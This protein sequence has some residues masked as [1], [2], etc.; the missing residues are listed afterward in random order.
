MT[1]NTTRER[2]YAGGGWQNWI[3]LL[4]GIWLFISP[5]ILQFGTNAPSQP[6]A[7]ANAIDAVGAAAWNAW[8]SA[9]AVFIVAATALSRMS[10][11]PERVNVILGIWIFVAP[12][13]LGFAWG[14]PNANWD[15]W[16]VGALVF[17]ISLSAALNIG[18][19]RRI[20]SA[21]G[22]INRR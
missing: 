4:L 1:Y 9:I 2:D 16:I 12:W 10:F 5:W 3:N 15:H 8:I 7:G 19:E 22:S 21:P 18:P 11:W 14:V 6:V 17:L 20:F 13:V